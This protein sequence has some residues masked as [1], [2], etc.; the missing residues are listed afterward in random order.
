VTSL[1]PL[2]TGTAGGEK[3]KRAPAKDYLSRKAAG[4]RRRGGVKKR[5]EGPRRKEDPRCR[6]IKTFVAK[7]EKG[8]KPAGG[9]HRLLLAPREGEGRGKEKDGVLLTDKMERGEKKEG[10]KGGGG[11]EKERVRVY[12]RKEGGEKSGRSLSSSW[13]WKGPRRREERGEPS[14]GPRSSY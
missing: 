8:K 11:G 1:L 10:G 4:R 5:K 12:L 7:K 14:M 2:A 6:S 9:Q 3:K 13:E